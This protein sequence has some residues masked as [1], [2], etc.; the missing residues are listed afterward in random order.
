[1]QFVSP[2]N[3]SKVVL[4]IAAFASLVVAHASF[5]LIEQR[6]R[7]PSG[8]KLSLRT[9]AIA[10]GCITLPV[11]ATFVA[12]DVEPSLAA[13][14][15]ERRNCDYQ[16]GLAKHE[17]EGE[18]T[19]RTAGSKG[20]VALVGDSMA[21]M[22]SE[23]FVDASRGLGFD[24][25]IFTRGATPFLYLDIISQDGSSEPQRA[26]VDYL[27]ESD[28]QIVVLSQANW[29]RLSKTDDE[30]KWIDFAM[31][32]VDE[33]LRAGIGIV[34]VGESPAVNSDPRL[35]SP[36]QIR[37]GKCGAD[38]ARSKQSLEAQRRGIEDELELARLRPE[39]VFF[40]DLPHLCP[41][42]ECSLRRN[43]EWWWRDG[44]HISVVASRALAGPL[45]DA[46]RK[47]LS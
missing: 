13:H 31:P 33:L 43:G 37:L 35:C 36:L 47:A 2:F 17:L 14:I 42:D 41:E 15:D 40:D 21:G 25:T 26:V 5:I 8:R 1:M 38:I 4:I 7:P 32:V 44:T 19:F 34:L 10:L 9:V 30:P 24:A 3:S 20:R 39:V 18:C 46:M 27:V 28:F 22:L 12:T 6:F 11:V 16:L 23:G 45:T 29:Y